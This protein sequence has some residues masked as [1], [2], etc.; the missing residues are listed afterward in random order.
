MFYGDT[1]TLNRY[2]GNPGLRAGSAITFSTTSVKHIFGSQF[3]HS[4]SGH[5]EADDCDFQLEK[6][7]VLLSSKHGRRHMF[8]DTNSYF[9]L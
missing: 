9:N 1:G 2:S 4:R 6:N 5:V 3:P 7:K 8:L